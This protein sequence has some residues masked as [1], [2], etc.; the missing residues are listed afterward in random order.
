MLFFCTIWF[1]GLKEPICKGF[2]N[3]SC[4]AGLVRRFYAALVRQ[5]TDKTFPPL[6]FKKSWPWHSRPLGY[7]LTHLKPHK[8]EVYKGF[9]SSNPNSILP[10]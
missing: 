1:S 6:V 10:P 5:K 8:S 4:N 2:R 7:S 9:H 3:Q